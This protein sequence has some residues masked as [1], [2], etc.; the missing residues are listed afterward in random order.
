M[1]WEISPAADV[2]SDLLATELDVP[3]HGIAGPAAP[4]SV[5]L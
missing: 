2:L 3:A 5:R 1:T 4:H